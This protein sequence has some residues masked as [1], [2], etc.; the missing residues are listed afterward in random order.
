MYSNSPLKSLL[1]Y[2]SCFIFST[3]WLFFSYVTYTSSFPSTGQWH[4]L[5]F[6]HDFYSFSSRC[7]NVLPWMLNLSQFCN[8]ALKSFHSIPPWSFCSALRSSLNLHLWVCLFRVHPD[9]WAYQ[10]PE[11][12]A[13]LAA[14]TGSCCRYMIVP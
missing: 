1:S 12:T 3:Y 4:C 8:S 6:V 9:P 14:L 2:S 5:Q 10:L 11:G 7:L 13:S